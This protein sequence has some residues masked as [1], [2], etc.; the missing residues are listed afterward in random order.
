ME[1]LIQLPSTDLRLSFHARQRMS[2][3]RVGR[4]LVQRTVTHPLIRWPG[5]NGCTEL[6]GP[7]IVVTVDL[8]RAT[9]VTVKLRTPVP[10]QHGL[11]HIDNLPA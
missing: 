3:L 9:I 1:N 10:Y 5:R 2:E 8:N 4:D 6:A 11:H 7:R